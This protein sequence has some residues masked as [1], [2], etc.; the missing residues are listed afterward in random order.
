MVSE[1]QLYPD[2]AWWIGLFPGVSLMLTHPLD[3]PRRRL[4]SD[5]ARSAHELNQVPSLLGRRLVG[6]C[7]SAR[8]VTLFERQTPS[9][10][11]FSSKSSPNPMRKRSR[12]PF[13]SLT[14]LK[15]S[16]ANF[17]SHYLT[18]DQVRQGVDDFDRFRW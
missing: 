9:D 15:K 17:K 12:S 7:E 14:S 13:T 1:G 4:A 2:T 8:S 11:R 5:E 10:A 18:L 3:K 16:R 6:L